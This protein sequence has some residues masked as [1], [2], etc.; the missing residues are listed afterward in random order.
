[1][2]VDAIVDNINTSTIIGTRARTRTCTRTR[3]RTR[4]RTRTST[5]CSAIW[6][7]STGGSNR[8]GSLDRTLD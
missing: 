8:L 5:T 2:A 1:V 6:D 7:A 4:T 3:I